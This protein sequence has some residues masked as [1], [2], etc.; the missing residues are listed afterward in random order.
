LADF[1]LPIYKQRRLVLVDFMRA[2]TGDPSLIRPAVDD[3]GYT[4][5][6]HGAIV[7]VVAGETV[8]VR[9][10][11]LRLAPNAEVYVTSDDPTSA[12]IV[13]PVG[14]KLD[15][16]AWTDF[17]I[18]GIVGGTPRV[19]K[20]FAR[21]G[22]ATGPIIGRMVAWVFV[23]LTVRITPHIVAIASA[24]GAAVASAASVADVM[25][26]VQAIWRPC[27]VDFDVKSTVN[28]AH[29]FANPGRIAWRS[30]VS[31]LLANNFAT[32][33]INAHF[34]HRIDISGS[35]GVLGLGF[36]PANAVR[37]VL[38]HPGV[39]LGDE[40][41]SGINRA[42]DAMW[43]GND[44][45]HELGHFFQL[46]HPEKKDSANARYD[47]WSRR[48][49]MH[50]DN[51]QPTRG[52]WTDQFGYGTSGTGVRRGCMITMKNLAQLTTDGECTTARTTISTPPGPYGT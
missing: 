1:N 35:T 36:S 2:G 38:P 25:T 44:L 6:E 14:G 10:R 45:A 30:E 26:R 43:L 50:P 13:Y 20:L 16:G 51:L 40:T 46:D 47:L 8:M 32:G 23:R 4:G 18:K 5:T 29:T 19:V 27:G 49:L 41:A 39:I 24:T 52:D 3:R 48:M 33:N 37:F 17:Q 42:G 28:D 7:G 21:F 12:A 34:V 11:R 9:L 31:T 15:H 22:S